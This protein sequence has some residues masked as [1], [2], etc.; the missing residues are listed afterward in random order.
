MDV[1]IIV[2]SSVL[3]PALP[4]PS[5]VEVREKLGDTATYTISFADDICDGDFMTLNHPAFNPFEDLAISVKLDNKDEILL[6]KGPVQKHQISIVHGGQGSKLQVTGSDNSLKMSWK[7]QTKNWAKTIT[8]TEIE[9][10]L[11]EYGFDVTHVLEDEKPNPGSPATQSSR[12]LKNGQVQREPNLS[13]LKK[14]AS[15][16]SAYFWVSYEGKN[17]AANFS[18]LPLKGSKTAATKDDGTNIKQTL[19]IN[20]PDY[21]ITELSINWDA[22]RPTSVQQ[23][24]VDA[25]TKKT[26]KSD[27]DNPP[28]IKLGDIT[29]KDLT[30]GKVSA[31]L[32]KP[33]DDS[34]KID[35]S[36]AALN[37]A[38]WFIRLTCNAD[39]EKFCDGDLFH[40][41]TKVLLMGAGAR[42]DGEYIVSGVTHTIDTVSYK[43]QLEL[44]RNA[45]TKTNENLKK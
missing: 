3:T 22:N 11:K 4:S 6:V 13:F 38:E 8:K 19:K 42:Y 14:Q 20:Y 28:Q 9:T 31:L 12:S 40:A 26:K 34:G 23:H 35:R 36:N 45:W 24:E 17:V 29:L 43:V 10:I 16:M 1:Q 41:H 25:H 37:D 30:E 39:F 7:P 44:M 33:G 18:R 5:Q 2:E 27:P 32:T 21:N 15:Q